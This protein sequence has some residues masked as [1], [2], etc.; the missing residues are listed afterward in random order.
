V[1]LA[2][3][4]VVDPYPVGED[5]LGDDLA[6]RLRVVAGRTVERRVAEGVETQR[7]VLAGAEDA[8]VDVGHERS[9]VGG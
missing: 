6:D 9:S 5:C 2:E 4:D 3:A 7:G 8:V 1:V